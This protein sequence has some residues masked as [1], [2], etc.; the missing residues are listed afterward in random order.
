MYYGSNNYHYTLEDDQIIIREI[1]KN[2][3]NMDKAFYDAAHILSRTPSA[4]R[5]R[6]YNKLRLEDYHFWIV[7]SN[8]KKSAVN[9][10]NKRQEIVNDLVSDTTS[11]YYKMN[12]EEKSKFVK[13]IFPDFLNLF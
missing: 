8:G 13:S 3:N 2:L 1:K 5:Q 9:T 4:V 10:K 12:K 7:D 6:W 11:S